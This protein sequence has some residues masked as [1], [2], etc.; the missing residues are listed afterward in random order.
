MTRKSCC[1]AATAASLPFLQHKQNKLYIKS[2]KIVKKPKSPPTIIVLLIFYG[3]YTNL[4]ADFKVITRYSEDQSK[5]KS[6]INEVQ[7][8]ETLLD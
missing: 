5:N 7:T 3:F 1:A 4:D 8:E 2:E 6:W